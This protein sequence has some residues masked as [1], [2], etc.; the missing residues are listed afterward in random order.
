MY[1]GRLTELEGAMCTQILDDREREAVF[2][3]LNGRL[4]VLWYIPF[5]QA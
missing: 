3:S 5:P 4:W 2:V 1:L